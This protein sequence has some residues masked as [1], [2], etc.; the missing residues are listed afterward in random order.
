M[1]S[2]I[3]YPGGIKISFEDFGRQF[4]NIS[5]SNAQNRS[6]ILPM[7]ESGGV[8][9][10]ALEV[11]RACDRDGNG[12]LEWSNGEVRNFITAVF[13]RHGLSPP[14]M[15]QCWELFNT[16]DRDQSKSLDVQESLCLVDAVYRSVFYL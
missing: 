13:T 1:S 6:R 12:V 14:T 5:Q 15:E 7:I 10:D 11:Y 9:R 16:F 2:Y 3:T 8:L 4:A